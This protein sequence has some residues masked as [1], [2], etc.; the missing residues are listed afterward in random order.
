MGFEIE[1]EDFNISFYDNGAPKEYRSSLTIIEKDKPVYQKNII[2]NNPLHY[3]GINI[4][5]SVRK[6][7]SKY[8]FTKKTPATDPSGEAIQRKFC[9][10]K[11]SASF[12]IKTAVGPPWKNSEGFGKFVV[13]NT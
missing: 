4:F 1:C 6:M 5:R 12:Q 10:P 13:V 8:Q 11:I 2:V 3:R 7:P 9:Q